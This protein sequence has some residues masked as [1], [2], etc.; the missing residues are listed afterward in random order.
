MAKALRGTVGIWDPAG[1]NNTEHSSH[2]GSAE[3]NPNRKRE[4]AGL[5]PGLGQWVKDPV[6]LELWCR[7]QTQLGSQVAVALA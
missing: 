5:I 1:N 6:L 2:R 7:L 4:G 3:T